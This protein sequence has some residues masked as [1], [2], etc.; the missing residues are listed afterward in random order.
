MI[1]KNI[2]YLKIDKLVFDPDN[3]RLPQTLRNNKNSPDYE[4]SVIDWML[5][6]ENVTELMGS[7]GEKGFFAAEPI[8]V[9]PNDSGKFEVVEGN[10]RL[11]ALKLLKNP[12]LA[13]KKKKAIEEI[14]S[15]AMSEVN[16]VPSIKFDKREEVLAYLGYK[17][18]TG[19]QP[20]DSLAKAKYLRQLLATITEGTLYEKCRTLAKI[21][22][23]KANYVRLLLV[24]VDIYSKI[25]EKEFYNISSLGEE[26]FEFGVFY[27][28]LQK[29][30]IA[31]YVGVDFDNDEP[32]KNLNEEHL[33]DVTHWIFERNSEGFTRLG[34]SRNLPKLNKILDEKFPKAL[35]AF[36]KGGKTLEESVRL[37][38][39]PL[40]VF[41]NSLNDSLSL[42]KISRDYSHEV[43][44]PSD[45]Q[46]DTL[47]EIRLIAR[48][49]H[50]LVKKRMNDIDD[51]LEL[52]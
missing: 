46:L 20:W 8:L 33:K 22:G 29:A 18:I 43:E 39:H 24:G 7:I 31:S 1:A 40:E 10:R 52:L 14:L 49:L 17:H 35:L 6:F 48:D 23:S 16:E 42:L 19:V 45:T 4:K 11:T 5:Q 15:G 2:E 26:S 34:E 12:S 37:T 50:D 27:T 41:Q 38:D 3:P 13:T 47:T 32:I 28:A 44:K 51:D 36:K 30:N 21:I 25:E 9:V